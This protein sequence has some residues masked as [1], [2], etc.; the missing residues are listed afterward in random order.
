MGQLRKWNDGAGR[1][2][3]LAETSKKVREA[4]L[5]E[6][7]GFNYRKQTSGTSHNYF[8]KEGCEP[9]T[10]PKHKPVKSV[11][12]RRAL[13]RIEACGEPEENVNS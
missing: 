12:V 1:G 9:F 10:I 3:I 5:L 6:Y 11:Y 13:A 8:S 2:L 7:Y 4:K